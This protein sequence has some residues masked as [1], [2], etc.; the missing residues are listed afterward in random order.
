[1][2]YL[3]KE[4]LSYSPYASSSFIGF[5]NDE[6]IDE[7]IPEIEHLRECLN[8]ISWVD[9]IEIHEEAMQFS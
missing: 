2:F 3:L 7:G 5:C 9:F 6:F 1:M 4:Q 8:N